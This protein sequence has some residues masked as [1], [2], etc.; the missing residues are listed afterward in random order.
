MNEL[1][2][3]SVKHAYVEH[4]VE[5]FI[6]ENRNNM[7]VKIITGHSQKMRIIVTTVAKHLGYNIFD[8]K[9][10]EITIY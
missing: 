1:D 9:F 6:Y 10:T 8:D 2:L 7:P 4:M 3:H 5:T